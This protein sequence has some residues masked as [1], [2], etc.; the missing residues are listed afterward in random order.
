MITA[1]S[2]EGLS[3]MRQEFEEIDSSS[4]MDGG[5]QREVSPEACCIP[6]HLG[7]EEVGIVSMKNYPLFM[8]IGSFFKGL[9][10]GVV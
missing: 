5:I 2:D 1:S 6:H 9:L 7:I 3:I 10:E 8:N 4:I